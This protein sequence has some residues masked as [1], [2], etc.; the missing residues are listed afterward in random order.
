ME[1][2]IAGSRAEPG[3]LAYHYA[4]DF[5]TPGLFR[6]LEIFA[7]EAALEAHRASAH[8]QTWRTVSA[9]CPREERTL[10]EARRL[11]G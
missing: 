3:C 1:A 7:D 10:Y 9:H 4:E 5:F 11:P 6:V 2:V 8:F